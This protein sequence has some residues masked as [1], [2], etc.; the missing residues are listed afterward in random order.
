[1]DDRQNELGGQ[2]NTVAPVASWLNPQTHR[3]SCAFAYVGTGER[4]NEMLAK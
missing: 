2:V 3:V 4:S 1:M